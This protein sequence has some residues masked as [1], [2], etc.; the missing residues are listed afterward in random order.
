[1]IAAPGFDPHFGRNRAALLLMNQVIYVAF[2]SFICDNPQPFSGWVFGY[3][4]ADLAQVANWRV[5]VASPQ[6]GGGIWQ[7]GRGLV[8]GADGSIYLE[9]GNDASFPPAAQSLANSFVNAHGR[10]AA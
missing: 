5:P 8:G 4:A 2:A 6:G 3:R 1:M 7:S 9:T 10:K